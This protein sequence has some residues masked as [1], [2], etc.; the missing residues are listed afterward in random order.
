MLSIR[1]GTSKKLFIDGVLDNDAAVNGNPITMAGHN[2]YIGG[3]ATRDNR[4]T[5]GHFNGQIADLRLYNK[6]LTYEERLY[7][8]GYRAEVFIGDTWSGRAAAAPA[9]ESSLYQSAA[10]EGE[11]CMRVEYTGSGAVSRLVPWDDGKHPH[12]WNSDF[13]LGK[14]QAMVLWVKGDPE[15]APGTLFAQLTTVVPSGHTQRVMYDGD[16]TSGDWE[17]WNISLKE[18]ST[19]KPADP[20]EEM[21]LPITKIK[22]VGVGVIGAGGGSVYIDDIRLYPV[23]CVPGFAPAA[24]L[25]DDC[26]VDRDDALLL[27][28]DFWLANPGIPGVRYEYY[29]ASYNSLDEFYADPIAPKKTGVVSNFDISVRDRGDQF[30]F[31][32]RAAVEA[33]ADGVYTFYTSSDDGSELYI[34][35]NLVVD[36]DGLHGMQWRQGDVYLTAGLHNIMVTMFEQGGGEGLLVDVEGPGIPRMAIPDDVLFLPYD[37]AADLNDDGMVNFLDYANVLNS[38]IDAVLWPPMD[39][40]LE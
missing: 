35:G 7:L 14:A 1:E 30:A 31:R 32:F 22:D 29:E 10:H 37:P 16:I 36:N 27:V 18:L 26:D 40:W 15:N 13:S 28:R 11:N 21:G 5:E 8:S 17:E 38:F 20:I 34:N 24:D 9:L 23:R 4:G 25:D 19:G 3:R 33:P 12:G 2:V 39:E 6:A